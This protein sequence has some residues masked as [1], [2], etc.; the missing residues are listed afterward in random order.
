MAWPS[1]EQ[2]QPPG[3][4]ALSPIF[5]FWSFVTK[6]SDNEDRF[7]KSKHSRLDI[8]GIREATSGMVLCKS[9]RTSEIKPKAMLGSKPS[10]SVLRIPLPSKNIW[11]KSF[12]WIEL[13]GDGELGSR[14]RRGPRIAPP[15]RGVADCPK[16]SFKG[17]PPA[18]EVEDEAI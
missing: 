14:S 4:R 18:P 1:R 13:T 2:R 16:G 12:L 9:R 10:R 11:A 7:F 5:K 3:R 8:S 15:D 17:K 6:D